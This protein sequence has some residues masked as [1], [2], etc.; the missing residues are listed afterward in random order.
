[1]KIALVKEMRQMDKLA[2]DNYGIPA[3]LLMENAGRAACAAMAQQLK[4]LTGKTICV[5]AGSG[6]NGGDA[7]AAVRY[8][9]N[10]GARVK[11]FL[12]GSAAH[13][14]P[15]AAMNRDICVKMGME[16]QPLETARDWEKLQLVLRF[17]NGVIDGLLGTGFSGPL[18]ETAAR[19]VQLVNASGCP[20]VA[21][22]VPSGINA[23]TGAVVSDAVQAT[24]TVTLGLPKPGNF[25]CPG[26]SYTGKLVVDDIG[27][28]LEL[29][30]AH[31]AQQSIDQ[32]LIQSALLPRKRDAHK[33]SCGRVLVVA[34]S[35]GMTG[36]AA[37]ASAA[38]LRAGAGIAVLAAA[39]SLQAVL[40]VK[41]TEVM[42]RPL[43]EAE[44]GVL[45]LT[46]LPALA[47]LAAGYDVLLLGPGLG[48][49]AETGELVRQLA[50]AANKPLVL[51]ADALFAYQGH[52]A[53][54]KELS[55]TVVLT[56]H[57]GEMAAL[58][59]ISVPALRADLLNLCR[60]A[61]REWNVI[62]VVK[63]ECTIVVYPDGGVYFT[64]T[65]NSGM[66]TAGSGDVLAGTIAGLWQQTKTDMAPLAGVYLHG[67][68][69]DLAAAGKA[70]GLIAG[71]ILQALPAARRTLSDETGKA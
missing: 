45:G 54:L 36:A 56:P 44:P 14:K 60:R 59:N 48:R 42:T 65:G 24:V 58:L 62:L 70:E 43:P 3:I 26:A 50:A 1:M 27:L 67:L 30:A 11:V 21:I 17:A 8:M 28:P 47:P 13:L 63:S 25:L 33:G 71:D 20:V 41:L 61:A 6:N 4:G 40:A 39:E 37:L 32:R 9:V 31:I 19:L 12:A 15:P 53:A 55:Q 68:A 64:S 23:D 5:L 16:I 18:R 46:A 7:F 66:A 69:G 34:G 52:T 29:L 10:Q 22:D 57:L 49:A 35:L 51:D 2:L 38:V